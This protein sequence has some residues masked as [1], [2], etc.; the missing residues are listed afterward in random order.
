MNILTEEQKEHVEKIYKRKFVT[1]LL[2]VLSFVGVV[3]LIAVGPLYLQLSQQSVLLEQKIQDI[4]SSELAAIQSE[5]DGAIEGAHDLLVL[6]KGINHSP[7]QYLRKIVEDFD[8]VEISAITTNYQTQVITFNGRADTRQDFVDMT[9]T[10]QEVPW[11]DG[12]EVPVSNFTKSKDIPF[13]L[14][15]TLNSEAYVD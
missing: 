11:A 8:G 7:Q 14:T 5:R 3:F 2:W 15:L 10:L 12:V 9:N 1:V 4:Q 6:F 13:S